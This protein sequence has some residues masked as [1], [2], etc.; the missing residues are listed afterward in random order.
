[1]NNV[2]EI[3]TPIVLEN[4]DFRGIVED[5]KIALVRAEMEKRYYISNYGNILNADTK[6]I[7]KQRLLNNRYK[8]VDLYY[9]DIKKN[10]RVRKSFLTHKL[11]ARAFCENNDK[12]KKNIVHHKDHDSFNNFFQNL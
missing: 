8:R 1:M 4:E 6:K 11:V 3:F 5:A 7:L 2:E 12:V 10:I 9:S